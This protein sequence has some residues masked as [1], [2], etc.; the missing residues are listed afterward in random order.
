MM[1]SSL[2]FRLSLT[3]LSL[4]LVTRPAEM[5]RWGR[6]GCAVLMPVEV[7]G[8]AAGRVGVAA[9]MRRELDGSALGASVERS[10]GGSVGMG[11]ALGVDGAGSS[12]GRLC[13]EESRERRE[14]GERRGN[15]TG[16]A[17]AW[18]AGSQQGR[19][20]REDGPLVGPARLGGFLFFFFFF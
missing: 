5:M 11:R 13:V 17:A 8:S 6:S 4:A 7:L 15:T 14:L 10:L 2:V 12:V 9:V 18:L 3:H 19:A 1:S 16:A 20:R